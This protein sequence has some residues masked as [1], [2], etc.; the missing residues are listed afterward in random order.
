MFPI[1]YVAID[2]AVSERGLPFF[3]ELNPRS[4]FVQWDAQAGYNIAGALADALLAGKPRRITIG[5][6]PEELKL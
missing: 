6:R 1:V 4:S 5:S 3:L 2:I